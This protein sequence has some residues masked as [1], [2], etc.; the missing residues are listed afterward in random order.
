MRLEGPRNTIGEN[1]RRTGYETWLRD[2]KAA[3]QSINMSYDDW[4]EAVAFSTLRRT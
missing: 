2:V 4:L 3:L 1:S